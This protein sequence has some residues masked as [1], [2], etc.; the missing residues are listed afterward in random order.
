MSEKFTL[1]LVAILS[2][3]LVL[4]VMELVL[5]LNRECEVK[6]YVVPVWRQY[7][8]QWIEVQL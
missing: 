3:L 8:S 5:L 4:N 2:A 6:V 1:L 7:A